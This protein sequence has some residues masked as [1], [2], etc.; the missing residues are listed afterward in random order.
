MFPFA[1]EGLE[2][3][4]VIGGITQEEMT[5]DLKD[6]VLNNDLPTL[7]AQRATFSRLEECMDFIGIMGASDGDALFGQYCEET[8]RL[9][10]AE[11]LDFGVPSSSVRTALRL[12]HMRSLHKIVQDCLVDPVA[13]VS[14]VYA[15]PLTEAQI[16]RL[17]QSAMDVEDSS[18]GGA[19]GNLTI[20]IAACKWILLEQLQDYKEPMP[21]RSSDPDGTNGICLNSE[22]MYYGYLDFAEVESTGGTLMDFDWFNELFPGEYT[23]PGSDGLS[24]QHIKPVYQLL[25]RLEK[26]WRVSNAFVDDSVSSKVNF[27]EEQIHS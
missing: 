26:E 11:L 13:S 6:S 25:S 4:N 12:K 23:G 19:N 16:E 3:G 2:V 21:P 17:T 27:W 22:G 7:Q 18:K 5:Q 14:A 10:D 24:T 20:L 1:G 15:V 9:S 8:L